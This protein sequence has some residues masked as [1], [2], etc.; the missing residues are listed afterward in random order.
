MRCECPKWDGQIDHE[1]VIYNKI[2]IREREVDINGSLGFAVT[3]DHMADFN[4]S[5]IYQPKCSCISNAVDI[6]NIGCNLQC[7]NPSRIIYGAITQKVILD[8]L[9]KDGACS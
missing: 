9:Y 6:F 1:L 4:N 5:K 3:I 7:H 2:I 8:S